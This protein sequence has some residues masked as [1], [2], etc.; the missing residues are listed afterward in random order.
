MLVLPNTP[1]V[2]TSKHKLSNLP[3]DL[4]STR[5]QLVDISLE[6]RR[7]YTTY[8]IFLQK[9]LEAVFQFTT[10]SDRSLLSTIKHAQTILICESIPWKG[11]EPPKLSFGKK[12]GPI[13]W[14]L[15]HEIVTVAAAISSSLTILSSKI[16][17]DLVDSEPE[18]IRDSG[19]LWSPV[20]KQYQNAIS[21]ANFGSE[22]LQHSEND[23]SIA[24]DTNCLVV[25]EKV[26]N[27]S[28]QITVLV[29]SSWFNR[30]DFNRGGTFTTNDNATLSRVAIYIVD[31][32]KFCEKLIDN[33]NLKSILIA[34][35]HWKQYLNLMERYATA[36]SVLFLSIDYYQQSKLGLAI[37][38]INFGL[39][40]LQAKSI[41][42]PSKDKKPIT[43]FKTK[44]SDRKRELFIRDLNSITT[45]AIDKLLFKTSSGAFL[46]DLTFLFDQ[47]IQ[48]HLKL[49]KE[50]D[51]LY[52]D[53][54]VDWKEAKKDSK[55]PTGTAIPTS[56]PKIYR[57][58]TI[59][60]EPREI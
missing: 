46:K 20:V 4:I 22:C 28:I 36:Y 31:E 21:Y 8:L 47:L 44:F 10:A 53:A 29:K 16:I 32:L 37:G 57:P 14:T 35:D 25:L 9:Y 43:K 55:W 24:I 30:L 19:D 41:A 42:N 52:F 49:S 60:N 56:K 2:P 12:S 38:L 58:S 33:F 18:N 34:N 13:R 7:D 54:I 11:L 39:L 23:D 50:N 1:Y 17:D 27:I 3:S 40:S 59:K 6:N 48:L 26:A 45:L 15:T 51:N 5:T